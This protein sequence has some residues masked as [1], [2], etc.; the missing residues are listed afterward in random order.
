M[1]VPPRNAHPIDYQESFQGLLDEDLPGHLALTDDVETGGEVAEFGGC[2]TA[3]HCHTLEVEYL[4]RSI[5]VGDDSVDT[6]RID[7]S[8]RAR[9]NVVHAV[10]VDG[11]EADH[12][13][14]GS[15]G[16]NHAIVNGGHFGIGR[17]PFLGFYGHV[18]IF[19]HGGGDGGGGAD[20]EPEGRLAQSDVEDTHFAEVGE[21]DPSAI[22]EIVFVAA[23]GDIY[24]SVL[25][26]ISECILSDRRRRRVQVIDGLEV[27]AVTE[28]LP[29]DF[30]YRGGNGDRGQSRAIIEK[31]LA[32]R[33]NFI[34]NNGRGQARA[35][36][37]FVTSWCS[38]VYV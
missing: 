23:F 29:S 22:H 15:H 38:M 11:G 25:G 36:I 3:E 32:Y 4:D 17:G 12:S 33:S 10:G 6:R 16:G 20:V 34:G 35:I 2:G 24:H 28:C 7:D 26:N 37:V 5:G 13:Q 19:R 1:C 9:L 31:P 27:L 8:H 21:I 30:S 14:A 18:F